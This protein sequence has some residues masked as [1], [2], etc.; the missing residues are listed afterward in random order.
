[1]NRPPNRASSTTGATIRAA[2]T[3]DFESFHFSSEGLRA[4]DRVP[5]YRDVIG[6][7]WARVDL[8]PVGEDLRI[9]ARFC[10]LPDLSVAYVE[11]S[12][13]RVTRTRA[14]AE[15]RDHVL[16][17]ITLEG[18]ATYSQ[19][20][21]E[22][23][24]SAGSAVV[25]SDAEGHRME[26]TT[27][28]SLMVGV[29]R[30]TLAPMLSNPDAALMSVIPDSIEPLRLLTGYT[31]ILITDSTLLDTVA[32]RCLAVSHVH[33]LI[34][35]TLGATSD[36]AQVAAG[37]GLRAARLRSIKV[38]IAQNLAGD[39][40][41]AALS[42]RHRLSPRYIRKLFEGENTSLSQFVLGHRLRRVH[43]LLAD[44]RYAERTISDIALAVGFGDISTFN[45]EFRRRFGMTPSDVRRGAP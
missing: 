2:A 14:M 13:V 10:R 19:R 25:L 43:R 6:R 11:G 33:D 4:V 38:D 9:D 22:A 35:L 40:T 30:T 23:T 27:S 42:A 31:R 45:R 12:A 21:C 44:P 17:A 37:R 24:I 15:G 34:A 39:V 5:F 36:A 20:G 32:L 29:P 41:V 8:E 1:V 3:G 26:R 7:M 28:R 18:A 16:L